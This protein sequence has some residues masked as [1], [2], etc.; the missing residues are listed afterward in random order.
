MAKQLAVVPDLEAELDKLF[1]L[2]PAEFTS[3]R[4]DLARRLKEA[5]QRAAAAT[6]QQLRKPT[7]AVWTVNQLARRHAKEI[8]DFLAAAEG[9]RSAQEEALGGGDTAKLRSATSAERQALRAL[10]QWAN[11]VL[12]AG[13]HAPTPAV[14]D[15]VASTLR[16]AAVDPRGRELLAAGR[17]TE[18]L[19]STGFGAFEGMQ[20]PA[21]RRR[22][23]QKPKR[24]DAAGERRRKERLR[25]LRERSKKLT[26]DAAEA[27]REAERAEA[28]A[29]RAR[30]KAERASAAAARAE[31]ELEAAEQE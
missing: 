23:E 18:E 26:A 9:L 22:R 28:E 29:G 3:A 1:G 2:P 25:K 21:Q 17:L 15:R 24:P 7:V 10:T 8:E 14:L 5:A 19:E 27:E 12:E 30:G 20:V 13:G 16:A 6:V 11:K 31:A 4:N